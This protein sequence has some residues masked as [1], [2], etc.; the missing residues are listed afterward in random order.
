MQL[1][2]QRVQE[3][4]INVY[5]RKELNRH[6]LLII[7]ENTYKNKDVNIDKIFEKLYLK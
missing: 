6:R 4:E 3:K 2:P 7:V 1:K 5:F